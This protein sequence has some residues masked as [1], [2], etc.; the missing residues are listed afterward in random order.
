MDA[1]AT[2]QL[3]AA[4]RKTLGLSQVELAERL[5]VTDKAVSRWETGRGMP[6][7]DS[8]EPLAEALDLS[9]SELLSGRELTAEELPR[10]AG[11]QI[12]ET[13]RKSAGMVW[14]GVLATL[15]VL[16]LLTAPF[17]AYHYVV[18]VPET[19]RAALERQAAEKQQSRARELPGSQDDFNYDALRITVTDRRGD[20]L[21][22]LCTDD[23]GHWCICVYDRDEIFPDRWRVNGGVFGMESGEISS[24]NFRDPQ[25]TAVIAFGGGDLPEEIAYY[26]FWLDGITYTCPVVEPGKIFDFFLVPDTYAIATLDLT[27]LDEDRQPLPYEDPWAPGT[28]S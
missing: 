12:V 8:L 3:I 2:G 22:A 7:I 18:S 15:L 20:Y 26:S 1:K 13:M 5:H 17:L 11:S 23:A 28:E 6:G 25:G 19:D 16:A 9:V 4:R 21:A 10:E 24:W 14:R 27:L